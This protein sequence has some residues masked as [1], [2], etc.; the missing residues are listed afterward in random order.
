MIKYQ[1]IYVYINI[2][3]Q[4][5]AYKFFFSEKLL[6]LFL[7]KSP[8]P[9]YAKILVLKAM[10]LLKKTK[11]VEIYYYRC[12]MCVGGGGG[13]LSTLYRILKHQTLNEQEEDGKEAGGCGEKVPVEVKREVCTEEPR[14]LCNIGKDIGLHAVYIVLQNVLQRCI[15]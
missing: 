3:N 13:G 8:T 12:T 7:M 5:Y 10:Y 2:N 1:H 6:G 11:D 14:I 9:L 4:N 15:V